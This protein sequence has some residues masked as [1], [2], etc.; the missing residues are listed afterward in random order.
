MRILPAIALSAGL[1]L[2]ACQHP[3]G[4]TDWGSTAALGIGTA[5]VVGLAVAASNSNNNN[6]RY[7]DGRRDYRRSDYRRYSSYQDRRYRRSVW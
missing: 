5:A 4:S 6:N 3:D 2:G 1:L 7:Y